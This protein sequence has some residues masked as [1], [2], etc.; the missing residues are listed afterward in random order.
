MMF[1]VAV[2]QRVSGE[3]GTRG[4]A[5]MGNVICRHCP[6]W[7][8]GRKGIMN[9]AKDEGRG[10]GPGPDACCFFWAGASGRPGKGGRGGG[11]MLFPDDGQASPAAALQLA[12]L[13]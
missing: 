7:H 3:P 6:I 9:A 10:R 11:A 5:H 4:A 12:A 2:R 1:H 13:T 8:K